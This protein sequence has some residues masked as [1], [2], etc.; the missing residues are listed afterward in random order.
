MELS[1]GVILLQGNEFRY[2]VATDNSVAVSCKKCRLTLIG[3]NTFSNNT[4]IGLHW[5]RSKR[6]PGGN[7]IYFKHCSIF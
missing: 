6:V 1:D 3:N 5:W 4:C 7:Y 2:N